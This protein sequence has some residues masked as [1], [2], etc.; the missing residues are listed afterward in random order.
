MA[1]VVEPYDAA[2]GGEGGDQILPDVAVAAETVAADEREGIASA[3]DRAVDGRAIGAGGVKGLDVA[4]EPVRG[5]IRSG[6]RGCHEGSGNNHN[7]PTA[8]GKPG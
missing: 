3:G 1:T 7:R 4:G 2:G 6:V 5:Q 8:R